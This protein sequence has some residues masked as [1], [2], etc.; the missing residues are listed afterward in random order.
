MEFKLKLD[1]G[2]AQLHSNVMSDI[3]SVVP[4]VGV[5]T[6]STPERREGRNRSPHRG[7]AV[8]NWPAVAPFPSADGRVHDP[9]TH[10]DP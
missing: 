10:S 3:R 8:M 7:N 4:V 9:L 5:G 2:E 1:A 6:I